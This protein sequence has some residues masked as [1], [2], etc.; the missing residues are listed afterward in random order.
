VA[1]TI[2]GCAGASKL[3][4]AVQDLDSPERLEALFDAALAAGESDQGWFRPV[5]TSGEG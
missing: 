5:F 2:R 4:A 1:W 3:R